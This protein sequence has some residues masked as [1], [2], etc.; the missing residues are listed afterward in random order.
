MKF[1]L[2]TELLKGKSLPLIFLKMI[3]SQFRPT[4]E[5]CPS[6]PGSA[7]LPLWCFSCLPLAVC[8]RPVPSM[9]ND[10]HVLPLAFAV[11]LQTGAIISI[12]Q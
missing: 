4:Q 1:T 3:H 10:Y 12:C 6:R 5:I 7:L 8:V 9:P 2:L 11:L